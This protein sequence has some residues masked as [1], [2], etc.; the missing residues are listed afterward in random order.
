[1]NN[2]NELSTEK[3][4]LNT[5]EID[6]L[7]TIKMLEIINKEDEIV[8]TAVKATIPEIVKV[9]DYASD[10]IQLG[11]RIIYIGAGTSGRLGVLDASECSPTYGV[12]YEMVQGVIAGG[13]SAMFKAKEGSEDDAEMGRNDLKNL[14]ITTHDTIIGIAA[15]GRTPYVIGALQYANEIGAF[16]GAISCVKNSVIS[17]HATAKIEA[18]TGPEV[19]TGSTRMKAG[20]AQKMI[21]NMISTCTMIKIGKVYSN[22][23]VDLN[24]SNEKL[25]IRAKNIIKE[26]V[27]CDDDTCTR[28]FESSNHDIKLAICMGLTNHSSEDCKQALKDNRGFLRQAIKHLNQL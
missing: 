28:L 23:M 16:T 3:R 20:T 22:Y 25:V 1:M 4:N 17:K 14:G 26:I 19:I 13:F 12:P 9:V 8:T 5:I 18:V 2:I 6:T 7:S 11:G 10:H 15:S 21:L 24:P 27:N